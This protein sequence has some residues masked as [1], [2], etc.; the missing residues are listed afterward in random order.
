ML[1]FGLPPVPATRSYTGSLCPNTI[2]PEC[3]TMFN[4]CLLIAPLGEVLLSPFDSW[5]TE[6]QRTPMISHIGYL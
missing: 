3:I 2:M 6:A 4:V 5:G 1:Q